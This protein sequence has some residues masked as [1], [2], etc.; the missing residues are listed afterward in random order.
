MWT[1]LRLLYLRFRARNYVSPYAD[2][3]IYGGLVEL[4]IE[5]QVSLCELGWLSVYHCG[6]CKVQSGTPLPSDWTCPRG[7]NG[8]LHTIPI[9]PAYES[10][11]PPTD[12]FERMRTVQ[13]P[14]DFS[15]GWE[16]ALKWRPHP[17]DAELYVGSQRY[18]CRRV[19]V[20]DKCFTCREY[21]TDDTLCVACRR[22]R[23]WASTDRV[24]L[25]YGLP[26]DYDTYEEETFRNRGHR[27]D[28]LH[29]S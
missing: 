23:N 1:R 2:F 4:T 25:Q 3:S 27:L 14:V 19:K 17:D 11:D 21:Y 18:L 16:E 8:F 28:L 15:G 20:D 10:A 12:V 13:S 6:S 22:A 9:P 5:D 24:F 29:Q 7:R 26:P